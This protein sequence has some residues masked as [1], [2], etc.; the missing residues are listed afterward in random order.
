MPRKRKSWQQLKEIS[1]LAYQKGVV[2]VLKKRNRGVSV[3]TLDQHNDYRNF[4]EAFQYIE[5]LIKESESK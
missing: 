1:N 5:K 3:W 2:H 4:Y